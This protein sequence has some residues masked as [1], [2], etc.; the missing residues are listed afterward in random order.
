VTIEY[1]V[2]GSIEWRMR[3]YARMLV[4]RSWWS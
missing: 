1:E 4:A 2:R 3:D